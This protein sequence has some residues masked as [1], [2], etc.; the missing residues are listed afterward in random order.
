MNEVGIWDEF[1]EAFSQEM[2]DYYAHIR[3]YYRNFKRL[4]LWAPVIWNDF[5]GDYSSMLRIWIFK[6]QQER[7]HIQ[8]HQIIQDWEK[9]CA[10]MKVCEDALTRILNDE[11]TDAEFAEHESKFPLTIEKE[12]D[13]LTYVSRSS[14]ESSAS[15]KAISEMHEAKVQADLTIFCDEFKK[16]LRTWWD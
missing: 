14:P 10:S 6:M 3:M 16:S 5:N 13:G 1:W 4:V 11:Y 15:I 8:E 7:E 12:S 9:V 2:F